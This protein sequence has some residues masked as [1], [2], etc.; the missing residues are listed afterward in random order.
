MK[1]YS[2]S[3]VIVVLALTLIAIPLAAQVVTGSLSGTV[4]DPSGA[5][6]PDATVIL[7]NA[8]TG[9]VQQAMTSATGTFRFTLLQVGHYNLEVSK[10]GFK[11]LKETGA[12]VDANIEDSLGTLTLQLGSA[13]EAIEVTAAP[14]LVEATQAQISEDIT[15][16]A[17]QTFSGVGEDEGMDFIALTLPGVSAS[18]DNNFSNTNGVGFTV[19]GIRGRNNDQQIDGQN[20]NDNSVTGP[21]IF[22]SDPDFV[23]EYQA[24]TSNFGPEYGRNSGSVIN[25]VTKSGTNR[26]HGTIFGTET[27]SVL[28]SLTNV[29]KDTGPGFLGITKPPRFNQEFTGG[30]IGGPL[31]KDKVFVFG[32]FDDLVDSSKFIFSTGALSPT[33]AGV[34]AL[35]SCFPGSTSVAALNSYGPFAVGYGSPTI[36]GSPTM[37]YYDN[38]PV[39]NTTDPN[40][41]PSET[42]PACGYQLAAIQRTLP[43][44][45]HFYDWLGK[46]DVHFTPRDLVTF[47]YIFQREL[48]YNSTGYNNGTSAAAGYSFNVPSIANSGL[49][50]WSHTFNNRMLN[51]LRIGYQRN[52]VEFG[53]NAGNTV[54]LAGSLGSGLTNVS[55]EQ[56]AEQAFGPPT[57]IPQSRIVNSYQIQDNFEFTWG[58]HQ[59]KWGANI[60]N[61]R[62]PNIF[63][64]NYN[65]GYVYSAPTGALANAAWGVF[66]ANGQF[67]G[68]CEPGTGPGTGA[69]CVAYTPGAAAVSITQGNPELGF[70]E[71]DT[72]FYVGDDWKLKSNLTLNLGLTWSYLGQPANLFHQETVAQ[73]SG[74]NPFWN[75]GLPLSATTSPTIG[76]VYTLFG[77]SVGFAWSPSG[78]FTGGDKTVLRGGYRR[79]YDPAY[80]NTFIL[81]AISAPVVLSQ[82]LVAP[83][84][85]LPA[86]PF[87]PAVRSA[88]ASSLIEGVYDPRNFDRTIT[89]STFRPDNYDEWSFGIQREIVKNAVGE[90]RYVGNRGHNEFQSINANP[91]IAGLAA[92]YP[93]L[94][95]SG[96]TP[97]TT[98]QTLGTGPNAAFQ[99]N[100]LGRVSCSEGITN[101]VANTGYSNYNGLQAE[102]RTTNLFN[103]LTLRTNY[104]FSKTLDN[105][106]EIFS[107]GA[108]GNTLA[109]A[110]NVLNYTSQEYGISGIDFPNTWTL[111]FYEDIPLMRSQRGVL[112][113]IAGGWGFSGTYVLQSGQPYT[114]SQ[115]VIN[116]VSGGVANDTAFNLANIGITDTSRPFIGSLSAPATEV[117][118][119]AADACAVF[120]AGCGSPANAL[121]SLNGVNNGTVTPVTSNQVRFIANGGEADSIYG[122]PFGNAGRNILRD[123]HTDLGNFT[124]YK[125]IKFW[126][127]ATVQ[128]HMTMDNVFNHPNYGNTSPGINP[129]LENAGVAGEG[130]TFADPTVTSTADLACPA[131]SRCIFFGLKIAY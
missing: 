116:A 18:R 46:L 112:G 105:A 2:L 59:L 81:T 118:I 40:A 19:D 125:N 128:W 104:T 93:S 57:N 37:G 70:R 121:I 30:T 41:P 103:Q 35:A 45:F 62:S 73:Q 44:G 127:R 67:P 33:P 42:V 17:L 1:H 109:Y 119:Y 82:T 24:T 27:N 56:S 31:L 74:S 64:P 80:Y 102:F 78:R 97:C 110:Q 95:P 3:L 89:P 54:P 65:G 76:S 90:V 32:G 60:T 52:N 98:P 53:G 36:S 14:P 72:F 99:P 108:A 79:T 85:G 11:K 5:V 107:T 43:N 106:S 49:I 28:T 12:S 66:A 77:P 111:S 48:F 114:P 6:V 75:T 16:T 15:G 21:A 47:R 122:T 51:E 23:T 120:G 50:D 55:F 87:G 117:G 123:Y 124:L 92:S 26:W 9:A 83:T 7:T 126:E 91:Y 69:A 115:E 100:V 38:A 34:G 129:F 10:A 113:H 22:L 39:N 63:L 58:R 131:G 4:A 8:G 130:T 20:N 71:W 61:Q 101:E 94:V 68:L 96:V 29:E 86:A 84:T 13:S 25:V 88:Y